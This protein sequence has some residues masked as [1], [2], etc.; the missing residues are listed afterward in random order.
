MEYVK[1]VF[2]QYDR[3]CIRVYQAYNPVIAKEAV[4]LQAFG[5][6]CTVLTGELKRTRNVFLL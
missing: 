2:A 4:Q 1:E 3:Q 6:N 5:E